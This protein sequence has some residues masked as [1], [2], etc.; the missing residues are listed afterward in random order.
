MRACRANASRTDVEPLVNS[1]YIRA[2]LSSWCPGKNIIAACSQ[3]APAGDADAL[4]HTRRKAPCTS[5]GESL[6]ASSRGNEP[7]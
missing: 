2:G 3:R 4:F 6:K 7:S 1:D 5:L